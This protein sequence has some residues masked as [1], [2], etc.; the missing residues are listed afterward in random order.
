MKFLQILLALAEELGGFTPLIGGPNYAHILLKP[1]ENLAAIEETVVREKA[2][3]ALHRI[4]EELPSTSVNED[5]VPLVKVC[6]AG[7]DFLIQPPT[8]PLSG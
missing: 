5:F 3:Q 6:Y 7:K 8:L 2:V 4:G 1:L